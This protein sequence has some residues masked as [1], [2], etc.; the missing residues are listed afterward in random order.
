[1]EWAPSDGTAATYIEDM[2]C[3]VATILLVL[4]S[5]CRLNRQRMMNC[6]EIGKIIGRSLLAASPAQLASAMGYAGRTTINRLRSGTAGKEATQE[7]LRR[8]RELTGLS[9]A[10][11]ADVARM[12]ECADDFNVQMKAE[13]GVLSDAVRNDIVS[14]FLTDSYDLFSSDYRELRLNRWLLMK[15]HDKDAFFFMLSYFL[16]AGKE[17][18]FYDRRLTTS[19]RYGAVLDQLRRFLSEKFPLNA[20][21]N[22]LSAEI[23]DTPMA[24]MAYPCL[25]TCIRLGGIILKG[26]VSGYSEASMHDIMTKIEGIPDRTFWDEGENT[27]EVTFLKFVPV[28]DKGNGIYECFTFN[29]KTGITRNPAQ[30]YFYGDKGLGLFLKRERHLDYGSL[31][32]DWKTL[33]ITLYRDREH[34]SEFIWHRLLPGQ[35]ERLREIDRLFTDSFLNNIRYESL[36]MDMSCGVAICDV[37]VTKSKVTLLTPDGDRYSISRHNRPFLREVTPDM[38]TL[39]YRDMSDNRLY[40][41]WEQLGSRIPLAEFSL[42]RR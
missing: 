4:H 2:A 35:S 30:L 39:V 7:F 25:L 38:T 26:Y 9:E 34:S 41:E 8:L 16:L 13:F 24:R 29:F 42:Q 33:R 19:E 3:H 36:G 10:E 17:K 11:L 23:P 40:V 1:M 21:G 12:L 31:A 20:I 32:T 5:K 28:N 27:N 37:A 15:G 18:T 22:T 6:M 14:S